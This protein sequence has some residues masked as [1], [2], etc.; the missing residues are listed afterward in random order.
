MCITPVFVI[1]HLLMAMKKDKLF[2]IQLNHFSHIVYYE[3]DKMPW[4]LRAYH[5]NTG[6]IRQNLGESKRI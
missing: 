6:L 3:I 4:N 5:E 2:K 1:A